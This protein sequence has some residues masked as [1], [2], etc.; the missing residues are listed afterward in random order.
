MMMIN[1]ADQSLL[2][3]ELVN[4]FCGCIAISWCLLAQYIVNECLK[5]LYRATGSNNRAAIVGKALCWGNLVCSNFRS[6]DW[7]CS[8]G[9]KRLLDVLWSEFHVIWHHNCCQEL[10]FGDST[11]LLSCSLFHLSFVVMLELRDSNNI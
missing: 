6:V 5:C 11:K 8:S 7:P 9:L 2:E 4:F 3:L 10:L 1:E